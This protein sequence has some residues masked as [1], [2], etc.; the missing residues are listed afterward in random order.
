MFLIFLCHFLGSNTEMDTVNVLYIIFGEIFVYWY[1][2]VTCSFRFVAG[3]DIFDRGPTTIYRPH[4]GLVM[5]AGHQ[6]LLAR[7]GGGML[8]L[9][10]ATHPLKDQ[11]LEKYVLPKKPSRLVCSGSLH[12]TARVSIKCLW[13]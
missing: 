6:R 1:T 5:E 3:L 10:C 12:R 4:L 9:I 8:F 11:K 7:K 13:K 2:I